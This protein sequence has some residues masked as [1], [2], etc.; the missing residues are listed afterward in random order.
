[1][2]DEMNIRVEEIH[3]YV[4]GELD[5]PRRGEVERLL[6]QDQGLAARVAAYRSDKA[7]LSKLYGGL[8]HEPLPP[9]WIERIKRAPG[10]RRQMV[11]PTLAALAASLVLLVVGSAVVKNGS[12]E[13]SVVAQALSARDE[14]VAPSAV[15]SWRSGQELTE[16]TPVL[17]HTLAMNVHAPDLSAMGYA[18][19]RIQIYRAASETG[20]VELV[21]RGPD[22]RDFTLYVRRSPGKPRFD[23]FEQDNLR[24]C[25]WQDDVISTVMTG[26]MSAAEMQRL[27]SLAYN[28][29]SA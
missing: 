1:M 10:G 19:A 25:V 7:M 28:G 23:V 21:Y 11:L 2:S 15:I 18:L 9:A 14:S 27:A 6:E 22:D 24:I 5:E 12:L 17:K 13:G 20:S 26:H 16:A 8:S 4:D 29:L 3:A